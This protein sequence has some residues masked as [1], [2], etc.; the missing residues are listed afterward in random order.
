MSSVVQYLRS[1]INW[2]LLCHFCGFI[3]VTKSERNLLART[4]S[5]WYT[6]VIQ[7]GR[8]LYFSK[9]WQEDSFIQYWYIC[10][11]FV[12]ISYRFLKMKTEHGVHRDQNSILQPEDFKNTVTASS[13]LI[14]IN[15]ISEHLIWNYSQLC[16]IKMLLDFAWNSVLNELNSLNQFKCHQI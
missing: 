8:T 13:D 1:C 11:D 4:H 10:K 14:F 9:D 7:T 5:H 6:K 16:L 12:L 3:S 2:T 15:V